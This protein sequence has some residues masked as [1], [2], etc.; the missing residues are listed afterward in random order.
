[1]AAAVILG[2]AFGLEAESEYNSYV[3]LAEEAMHSLGTTVK[4][5]SYIGAYPLSCIRPR[6]PDYHNSGQCT[7]L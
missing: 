6:N 7:N 5:G 3:L 2:V 1:M 4:L